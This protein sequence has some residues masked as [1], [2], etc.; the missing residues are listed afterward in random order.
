MVIEEVRRST[1]IGSDWRIAELK[2]WEAEGVARSALTIVAP[3]LWPAIVIFEGDP[4]ISRTP[5]CKTVN[6]LMTSLTA[7][8]ICPLG[9]MKPNCGQ[10]SGDKI[11]DR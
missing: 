5:V 6:A 7:K 3:E 10:V 2:R 9:P 4:P 8:F 11:D 1:T